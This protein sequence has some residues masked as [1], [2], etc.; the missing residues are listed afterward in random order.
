MLASCRQLLRATFQHWNGNEVDTQGDA[1]FVTFA[2]ATDAVSAAIEMQRTLSAYGWPNEE[3]VRIRIGKHTGEPQF[4]AGEYVGLD[5]HHAARIMSAGHGGQVLLSQTTRELVKHDLP[6]GV[7]LLDLG[8]HRLKDLQHPDHLYQLNIAGLPSDFPPLKTL[9]S[10]PHTLPVPPTPLIGRELQVASILRLISREEVRLVT[11]TGAGGTG[12]TRMALRVAAELSDAFPD[13]VYFVNLAPISDPELVIATIAHVLDVKDVAGQPIL[14]LLKASLHEKHLLLLLDNFEQVVDAAVQVAMLLTSCPKLKMI[15]TS[16]MALHVQAEYEFAV[17]PLTLPDPKRLTDVEALSQYEAVALFIQR[18]Q[19]VKPEFY[20]S[21]ANAPAVAEICVRLDGL[22]L[23][24]ELAAARIKVLPLQAL[25]ARLGQRLAVLT[26]G[27][28]DVPARQ[29]TLRNTIEWSYQ[30]LQAS[31][32]RLFRRLSIFVNGCALDAVEAVCAAL[33]SDPTARQVLDGVASLVDKNLLQPAE[34]ERNEP[35]LVMLETVREYGLELLSESEEMEMTRQAHAAYYL[36]LAE[37][38]ESELQGTHQAL[39]E[40]WLELEYDNLLAAWKWAIEQGKQGQRVE[41][42]MRLNGLLQRL[43]FD[44]GHVNEGQ[45]F[46]KRALSSV[47]FKLGD[48]ITA[49][50]LAKELNINWARPFGSPY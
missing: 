42:V 23:A 6:A 16:R 39:W 20:L 41:M 50:A 34:Q 49:H 35:R 30:L 10:Q 9:A 48:N 21:N 7:N 36:V 27:V 38:A 45:S 29:Q 18:A 15:V 37:R 13:G 43:W 47:V 4:S 8:E 5:V 25:L 22:P 11:L 40:G 33:D 31:E 32:Q 26:S 2:R 19:A 1:F 46:Y 28:R 14:D 44:L 3:K 24:I 17:P 12:K